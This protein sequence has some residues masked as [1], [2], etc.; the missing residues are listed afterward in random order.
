MEQE[1]KQ[2]LEQKISSIA[3]LIEKGT[4]AN[5][6]SVK[7][8]TFYQNFEFKGSGFAEYNVFIA[9]VQDLKERYYNL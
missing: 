6:V 1:R 5:Q 3:D 9:K 4:D 8:V 7:D 2:E